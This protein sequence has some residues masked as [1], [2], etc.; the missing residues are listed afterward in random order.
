[1]AK[2]V[3]HGLTKFLNAQMRAATSRHR[4]RAATGRA[5]MEAKSL[6]RQS[7]AAIM[8]PAAPV[9]RCRHWQRHGPAAMPR[10]LTLRQ[11]RVLVLAVNDA[12]KVG[13]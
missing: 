3:K 8:G 12:W 2:N 5:A 4:R 10:T 9:S 11:R 6:D 7:K 13:G 1:M